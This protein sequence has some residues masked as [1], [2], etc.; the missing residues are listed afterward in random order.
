MRK[1]A[2]S[3]VMGDHYYFHSKMIERFKSL[4]TLYY[5][6]DTRSRRPAT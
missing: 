2:E 6:P 5:H 1:T 3:S 4:L